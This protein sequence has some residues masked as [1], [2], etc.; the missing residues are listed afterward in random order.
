MEET[1][2]EII[3]CRNFKR[4]LVQKMCF[5]MKFSYRVI[6]IFKFIVYS[7]VADVTLRVLYTLLLHA[8][9][10][11]KVPYSAKIINTIC[12]TIISIKYLAHK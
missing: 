1:V 11:M 12:Q 8:Q 2:E 9:D 10:K 5:K 7:K 4:A 3:K 6:L